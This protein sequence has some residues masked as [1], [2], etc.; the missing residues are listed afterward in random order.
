MFRGQPSNKGNCPGSVERAASQTEGVWG[1]EQ[2]LGK[3]NKRNV[4]SL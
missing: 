3:A 1:Q 4:S 2:W